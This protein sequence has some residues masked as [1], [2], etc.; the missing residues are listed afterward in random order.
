[1]ESRFVGASLNAHQPSSRLSILRAGLPI[2][3]ATD[4]QSRIAV[5]RG[6]IFA[7][8]G[9]SAGVMTRAKIHRLIHWCTRKRQ[10]IDR[11][12]SRQRA[13]RRVETRVIELLL[14]PMSHN[15]GGT[16]KGSRDAARPHA[17]GSQAT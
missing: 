12:D 14:E 2:L 17:I 5:G 8:S 7:A 11:A 1:M 16:E 15:R 9:H 13:G 4:S 10:Q 6:A 3:R